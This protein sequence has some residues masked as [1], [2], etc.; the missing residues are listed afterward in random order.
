M[1]T[2]QKP[3]SECGSENIYYTYEGNRTTCWEYP[4]CKDCGFTKGSS[5]ANSEGTCWTSF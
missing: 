3:C 1:R 5:S 2:G 4:T